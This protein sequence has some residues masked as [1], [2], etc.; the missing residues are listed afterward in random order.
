M[1]LILKK[2]SKQDVLLGIQDDYYNNKDD[3]KDDVI[4]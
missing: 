3:D 4:T 1:Q 2:L